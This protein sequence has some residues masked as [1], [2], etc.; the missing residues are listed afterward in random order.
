MT[1]RD[2]VA[3]TCARAQARDLPVRFVLEND[4]R[5]GPYRVLERMS[6]QPAR[7]G[8]TVAVRIEAWDGHPDHDAGELHLSRVK[9]ARL[10]PLPR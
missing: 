7:G 9:A 4:R 6:G 8:T 10:D 3:M 1:A 2:A 5:I